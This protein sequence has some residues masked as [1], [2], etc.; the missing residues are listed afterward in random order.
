MTYH[1]KTLTMLG[2][3][4]VRIEFPSN[5][6][7]SVAEWYLLDDA[8][9]LLEKYSNQDHPLRPSDF[10]VISENEQTYTVFMYENQGVCWWACTDEGDDP[11]VYINLDP[12]PNQ[13]FFHAESF[14][15]FVYTRVFDFWHWH[16]P[17]LFMSGGGD[18]LSG[19]ILE[20]LKRSFKEHPVTKG[21]SGDTQYRFSHGDQRIVIWDGPRQADWHFTADSSE[22]VIS[23]FRQFSSQ[24]LWHTN[25][26]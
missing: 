14:S 15:T 10:K 7:R 17:H 13:W 9:P 20:S 24:L 2:R 3:E 26:S 4:S 12:P 11:P 6:P 19:E 18:P 1:D 22:S 5:L 16:D 21:W 23:L 25:L 8:I